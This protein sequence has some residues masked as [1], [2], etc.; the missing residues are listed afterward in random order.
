LSKKEEGISR[1]GDIGHH[2]HLKKIEERKARSQEADLR[3]EKGLK[4]RKKLLPSHSNQ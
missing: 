1:R 3:I 2:H 4:K